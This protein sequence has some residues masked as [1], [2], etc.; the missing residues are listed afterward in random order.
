MG[1]CLDLFG[2]FLVCLFSPGHSY[3]Q[4]LDQSWMKGGNAAGQSYQYVYK[5]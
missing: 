3:K 5:G 1:F 4:K 2:E